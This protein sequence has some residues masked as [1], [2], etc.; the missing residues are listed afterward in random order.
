MGGSGSG[1]RGFGKPSQPEGSQ[2]SG[3]TGGGGGGGSADECA[4]LAF[5]AILQSPQP[6]VVQT[7][8]LGTVLN[9]K[10]T[11]GGPPVV[12]VTSDDRI[13]GGVIPNINR[14]IDCMNNGYTFVAEVTKIDGGAVTVHVHVG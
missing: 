9:L 6:G 2:G 4:T 5:T 3:S 1:S 7:L 14:V 11:N 8:A 13:A 12:A 10:S